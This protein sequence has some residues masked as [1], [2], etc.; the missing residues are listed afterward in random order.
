M[1]EACPDAMTPSRR[2]TPATASLPSATS[3]HGKGLGVPQVTNHE[4]SGASLQALIDSAN[5]VQATKA[6][7]Q[8]TIK[9]DEA[10]RAKLASFLAGLRQSILAAFAGQIDTLADFGLSPRQIVVR[11]PA[12]KIASAAKAKATRAARHTLGKVQNA[13]IK[14]TVPTTAPPSGTR[15]A[16]RRRVLAHVV[17]ELR[18]F[19]RDP[20]VAPQWV[21]T[22]LRTMSA[23][24]SGA[25]G[26]RPRRLCGRGLARLN[27]ASC[28]VARGG[29]LVP[30]GATPAWL[31][32]A[33]S[34][35]D[36]WA[37]R[38]QGAVEQGHLA[39]QRRRT[40]P[41]APVNPCS[42]RVCAF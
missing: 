22:G 18:E 2:L 8:N 28:S 12:E 5:A 7:S 16:L 25:S 23:T 30:H 31:E 38:H 40:S 21:L 3:S 36:D 17:A 15:H 20:A 10:E 42:A 35:S 34:A 27:T 14:G 41:I 26:G 9:T 19:V 32:V 24:I 33:L 29:R 13:E 39:E 1:V 37:R 4:P 11:T 6:T